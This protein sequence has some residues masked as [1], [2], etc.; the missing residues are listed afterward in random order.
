MEKQSSRGGKYCCAGLPNKE[1][2]KNSTQIPGVS[3][4]R[5]PKNPAIRKQWTNFVRRYRLDFDPSAYT[6]GPFLFSS[7]FTSASYTR[8]AAMNLPGFD[9]E[10]TK[11]FLNRYAVPTIY[12][13][14]SSKALNSGEPSCREKRMIVK[15]ACSKDFPIEKSTE[16]NKAE[17]VETENDLEMVLPEA[18]FNVPPATR[19]VYC[20]KYNKLLKANDLENDE[21][22]FGT[23][24]DE[25][26]SML[27]PGEQNSEESDFGLS[28][29]SSAQ[30]QKTMMEQEAKKARGTEKKKTRKTGHCRTCGETML[31]HSKQKCVSK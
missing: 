22:D 18:D 16:C 11:R 5:F 29:E 12:E 6:A 1:S 27:E 10:N 25:T 26:E 28:D 7:H 21:V 31:G 2:C 15:E 19:D 20:E 8:G 13:H 30:Q 14:I 24:K 3:L 9:T 4:H 23:E 17:P